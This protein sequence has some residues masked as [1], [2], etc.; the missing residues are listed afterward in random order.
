MINTHTIK[1]RAIEFHYLSNSIGKEENT[2]IC[3]KYQPPT[4]FFKLNV[5]GSFTTS[6]EGTDIDCVARNHSGDWIIDSAERSKN[7]ILPEK[8]VDIHINSISKYAEGLHSP[9]DNCNFRYGFMFGRESARKE[10]GG[11]LRCILFIGFDCNV[12]EALAAQVLRKSKV[13]QLW[14]TVEN[15]PSFLLEAEIT[16]GWEGGGALGTLALLACSSCKGEKRYNL[17]RSCKIVSIPFASGI[18]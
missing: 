1:N 17:E 9:S 3:V 15:D 6:G 16:E 13:M 2:K 11:L 4:G 7:L 8:K 18:T 12:L 10:L 14:T 5:D